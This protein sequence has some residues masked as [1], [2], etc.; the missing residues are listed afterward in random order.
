MASS[1]P[2][3]HDDG[4]ASSPALSSA[5]TDVGDAS[6]SASSSGGGA[7]G[8]GLAPLVKEPQY[9]EKCGVVRVIVPLPRLKSFCHATVAGSTA[10]V[11]GTIGLEVGSDGVPKLA[12][13]GV[14]PQTTR[15][16]EC[17]KIILVSVE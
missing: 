15:T 11:S 5:S 4:A 7:G 17:I 8:G 6:S 1:A 13:G 2:V 10:Y 3:D 12:K 16:L 14:G 9:I